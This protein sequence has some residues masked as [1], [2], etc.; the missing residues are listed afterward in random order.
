M[1]G[2]LA[3]V[4]PGEELFRMNVW[5]HERQL[6]L[7]AQVHSHPTSAYHSETDDEYA[8]LAEV[9]GVSIVVPDFARDAFNLDTCAVYRLSS[10]GTWD[11]MTPVSVR[12]LIA[13]ED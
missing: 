3:V 6:R 9:G 8:T 13:I 1:G 2:G 7:I 10:S 12:T 5:L 11:E 4:V